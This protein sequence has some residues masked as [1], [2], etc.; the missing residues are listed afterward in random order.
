MLT[1]PLLAQETV[2]ATRVDYYEYPSVHSCVANPKFFGR[3]NSE[4]VYTF[5]MISE[6]AKT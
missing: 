6:D 2:V 3:E 1:I 5:K 4:I